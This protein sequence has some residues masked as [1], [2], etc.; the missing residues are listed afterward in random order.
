MDTAVKLFT[1]LL[2][3]CF[4]YGCTVANS[5]PSANSPEI[6]QA[7]ERLDR[8]KYNQSGQWR[9]LYYVT[10]EGTRLTFLVISPLGGSYELNAATCLIPMDDA[11]MAL[12][13]NRGT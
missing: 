12:G 8:C 13:A 5:V 11:I 3:S 2:C 9:V 7:L 6:E 1:L 10:E 4:I